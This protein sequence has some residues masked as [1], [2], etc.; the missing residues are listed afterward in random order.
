MIRVVNVKEEDYAV[1]RKLAQDNSPLDIHT[2][3]TYWVLTKVFSHSCF[4]LYDEEEAIGYITS[5][6]D[7]KRLLIWQIAV[8]KLYRGNGYSQMLIDKVAKFAQ[9]KQINMTVTIAQDNKASYNSFKKYCIDHTIKMYE[10][11]EADLI[12]LN[13]REFHENEIIYHM[14]F[15]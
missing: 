11:G 10:V 3:Y 9:N 2:Q 6:Y 15:L 5:V 12:D 13:D 7:E 14:D 4:I 1:M 8:S